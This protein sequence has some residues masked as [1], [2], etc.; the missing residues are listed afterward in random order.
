MYH[1]SSEIASEYVDSLFSYTSGLNLTKLG[2]N[3]PWPLIIVQM[4][5]VNYNRSNE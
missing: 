4:V 3:D 2:R 1:F 5:P